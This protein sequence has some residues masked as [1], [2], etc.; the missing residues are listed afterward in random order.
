MSAFST[1]LTHFCAGQIGLPQLLA[2]LRDDLQHDRAALFEH[3][4]L[5][6]SAWRGR[7]ID[8]VAYEALRG[9]VVGPQKPS[10]SNTPADQESQ[11][12]M[13]RDWHPSSSPSAPNTD[14]TLL[15]RPTAPSSPMH[16]SNKPRS[17][18]R[19]GGWVTDELA[20]S[21]DAVTEV[22]PGSVLKDRFVLEEEIGRG[23]MGT[24][25]RAKDIR[26][27]EAQDRFPFVAVK[28][29]NE[30]FRQ[31]PQSLK[32][33]QREAKKAQALAHPNVAGV[34][35]FDRD[36]TTVFLVMELLEGQSLE[37]LIRNRAGR[38]VPKPE[39]LRIVRSV[40][41]A[42]S[43][44]HE[45]GMLH[46]DFK[47]ANAFRTNEG[48]IKVLD[49]GIARALARPSE[50]K[51]EVTRFSVTELGALTPEYASC[52][53]LV[54][55]EP[56][57]SDDVFALACVTYE[58]L[59]GRHPFGHVS[60]LL[61]ERRGLKL[62]PIQGL[63]R[64]TW[65]ALAHGLAFSRRDRAA[66]IDEF[67]TE[68][69][70]RRRVAASIGIAASVLTAIGVG[71]W[72]YFQGAG[73]SETFA[74]LTRKSPPSQPTQ[75]M[76]PTAPP[77]VESA[78]EPVQPIAEPNEPVEQSAQQ[79]EE[80]PPE[81]VAAIEEPNTVTTPLPGAESSST[82]PPV[83]S[84]SLSPPPMD[85]AQAAVPTN[86]A[87]EI[88]KIEP[89][90]PRPA[91]PVKP[92]ERQRSFTP[93]QLK[94]RLLALASMD[95]APGALAVRQD[96]ERVA[97][98]GD[99]FLQSEAPLAIAHAYVRLGDKAFAA[100][101]YFTAVALHDRALELVPDHSMFT[102]RR[103]Y[104]KSVAQLQKLVEEGDLNAEVLQTELQNIRAVDELQFYRIRSRMAETLAR[105]ITMLKGR[106]ATHAAQLQDV[107]RE[108]FVGVAA[109]DAVGKLHAT[110]SE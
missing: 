75:T 42:L 63:D 1:A 27:E 6:E 72:F 74:N 100:G 24:V 98:P 52:E 84:P 38:G 41:A 31:H 46:A 102:E 53:M 70:P 11:T 10:I 106:D 20:W 39:A 99:E 77:I 62:V 108:V 26:K 103:T 4:A 67:L 64:H 17:A 33:L 92:P 34:Y 54:G 35:D 51:A 23:G 101:N 86:D 14:R 13:S 45:K 61:A 90:A 3:V 19:S 65:R 71:A 21:N 96:L 16:P 91:A 8:A 68:L 28:V 110:D 76:T 55:D 7:R 32:A 56:H 80:S 18:P 69:A 93:Q 5:I 44:A 88:P 47:P 40:G 48:A 89:E 95:D 36:G 2:V 37:E 49:F 73:I 59:A 9:V 107:G 105:R 15:R 58:L 29:L 30:G 60:A 82:E 109:F 79:V 43:Y 66:S 94:N 25:Y 87:V 78:A 22:R 104:M 97:Q 85:T 50:S 83:S 57:P 81:V 12:R